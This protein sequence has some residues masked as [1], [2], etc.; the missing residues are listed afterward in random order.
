MSGRRRILVSAYAC[1]PERGSDPGVGLRHRLH[2]AQGSGPSVSGWRLG[3]TNSAAYLR[4]QA[5]FS[6]WTMATERE[7]WL[8]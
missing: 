5:E 3:L 4:M 8:N 1:E 6:G 7:D 2:E